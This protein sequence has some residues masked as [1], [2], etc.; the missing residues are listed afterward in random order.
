[1]E[2]DAERKERNRLRATG[3]PWRALE[4]E[5]RGPD[6]GNFLFFF[7]T[8]FLPA[9]SFRAVGRGRHGFRRSCYRAVTRN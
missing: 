3:G 8:L 4:G 6:E 5:F 2:I 7:V 1:M 9:P